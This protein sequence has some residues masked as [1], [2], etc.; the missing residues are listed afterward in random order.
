MEGF[1]RSPTIHLCYNKC[2]LQDCV[3]DD[4]FCGGAYTGYDTESSNA[5]CADEALCKHLCDS[6]ESCKSIDM[7]KDKTRCFLNSDTCDASDSEDPV[8]DMNYD[9]LIKVIDQNGNRRLESEKPVEAVKERSL[10]PAMDSGYSHAKLLIFPN[11]KFTSGGT[12]KVG[13]L[14]RR[15]SHHQL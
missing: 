14:A 9:L 13:E 3:G 12:F 8:P 10:L 5:L 4:C 11:V 6:Y 15:A 1:D 7:A 2:I